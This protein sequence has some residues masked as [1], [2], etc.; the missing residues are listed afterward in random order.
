MSTYETTTSRPHSINT[1]LAVRASLST[2]IFRLQAEEILNLSDAEIKRCLEGC[3]L[4][5]KLIVIITNMR[6]NGMTLFD[7]LS[8]NGDENSLINFYKP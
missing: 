8:Y 4:G 2:L 7:V 5:S 3:A 6:N 1:L